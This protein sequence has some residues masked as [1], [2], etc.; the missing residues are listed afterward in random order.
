MGAVIK[1]LPHLARPSDHIAKEVLAFTCI[2]LFNAN[3]SVQV[4]LY[5][6]L[7]LG[8]YVIR[9]T[10]ILEDQFYWS[11]ESTTKDLSLNLKLRQ[12]ARFL[13]NEDFG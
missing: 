7:F 11:F 6:F 9:R 13:S 1:T 5:F 10:L 12:I 2:M 4:K 3:A 8:Y